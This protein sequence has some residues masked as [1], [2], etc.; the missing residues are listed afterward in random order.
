M[1]EVV[2]EVMPVEELRDAFDLDFTL[3]SRIMDGQGERN[4]KDNSLNEYIGKCGVLS[5]LLNQ[6]TYLRSRALELDEAGEPIR[7]P[8]RA[9]RIFRMKMPMDV[10]H[11]KLLFALIS[12]NTSLPTQ[13]SRRGAAVVDVANDDEN[14]AVD[15]SQPAAKEVTVTP[16]TY[17]NY[18]SA[19]KLWH[20]YS[21]ADIG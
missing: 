19:L 1:A 7:H 4:V 13:R 16:Q 5:K 11:V 17:Q 6:N 10:Q 20:A 9:Q 3:M 15:T 18:K 8:G 21:C 14:L 2:D 12:V